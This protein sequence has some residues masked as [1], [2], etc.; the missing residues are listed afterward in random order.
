MQI[1]WG[2]NESWS[3]CSECAGLASWGSGCRC[4][5]EHLSMLLGLTSVLPNCIGDLSA[6]QPPL[7]SWLARPHGYRAAETIPPL[8]VIVPVEEVSQQRW[9]KSHFPTTR[10]PARGREVGWGTGCSGSPKSRDW[11]CL[12][13]YLEAS[14]PLRSRPCDL[15]GRAGQPSLLLTYCIL[16]C[17]PHSLELSQWFKV[18]LLFPNLANGLWVSCPRATTHCSPVFFQKY[19]LPT[20]SYVWIFIYKLCQ[21]R[22]FFLIDYSLLWVLLFCQNIDLRDNY[23]LAYKEV[24]LFF[25]FICYSNV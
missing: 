25:L 15:A 18:L 22:F 17:V 23:I 12:T 16:P 6:G 2:C 20:Q 1:S 13:L 3:S 19:S 4:E 7:D 21:I 11:P 14:V 10:D 8:L 9:W 24:T 5:S